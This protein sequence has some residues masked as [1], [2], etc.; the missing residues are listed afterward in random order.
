MRGKCWCSRGQEFTGKWLFIM[1]SIIIRTPGRGNCR[2]RE[3]IILLAIKLRGDY[4]II[5]ES[6]L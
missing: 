1:S 2:G 6:D 5:G 4:N 3:K